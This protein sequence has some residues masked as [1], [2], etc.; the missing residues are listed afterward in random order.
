M[1]KFI[2]DLLGISQTPTAPAPRVP[3]H[4]TIPQP[5][6]PS[7]TVAIG[8]Q[9]EDRRTYYIRTQ[10]MQIAVRYSKDGGEGIQLDEKEYRWI[11]IN[12]FMMPDRWRQR[13]TPLMILFPD[14]YP[15]VPPTG[16]YIQIRARLKSGGHDTHAFQNRTIYPDAPAIK[17]WFWYCI[18]AQVEGAGGWQPSSDPKSPDNLFTFLNMAR[19]ALSTDE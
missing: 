16:F 15:D 10:A 8:G 2:A 6:P 12:K 1:W 3:V 4:R 13:C 17:G 18:H 5:A 11:V 9:R 14:A 19:E 7:R